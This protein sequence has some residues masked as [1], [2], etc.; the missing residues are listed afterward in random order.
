M[1]ELERDKGIEKERERERERVLSKFIVQSF[2]TE[3]E[4]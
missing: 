3:S 2:H 1:C 4:F